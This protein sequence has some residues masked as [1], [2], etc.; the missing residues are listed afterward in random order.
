MNK[1][2]RHLGLHPDAVILFSDLLVEAS[3]RTQLIVTTHSD[4][5]VSALTEHAESVLVCQNVRGTSLHR[6][7]SKRIAHLLDKYR[8]GEIWTMGELGGNP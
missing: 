7:E 3:S 1:A 2:Y 4:A 8:L 5:L 6:V